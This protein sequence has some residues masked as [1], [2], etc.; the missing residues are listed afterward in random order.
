MS[1][2]AKDRAGGIPCLAILLPSK[3]NPG[4]SRDKGEWCLKG[5]GSFWMLMNYSGTFRCT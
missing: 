2:V 3:T 4:E 1:A 5:A